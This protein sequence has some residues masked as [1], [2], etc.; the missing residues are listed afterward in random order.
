MDDTALPGA[1]SDQARAVEQEIH[2]GQLQQLS[3]MKHLREQ[4]SG[5]QV[6]QVPTG[7]AEAGGGGTADLRN[8]ALTVTA[9]GTGLWSWPVLPAVLSRSAAVTP[10]RADCR[11]RSACPVTQRGPVRRLAVGLAALLVLADAGLVLLGLG[12]HGSAPPAPAAAATAPVRLGE[13]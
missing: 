3:T 8:G 10:P 5:E 2:D 4:L 7:A 9:T 12:T 1:T 11:S 6:S 13:T